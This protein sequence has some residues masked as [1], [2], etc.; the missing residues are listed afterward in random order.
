MG[1]RGQQLVTVRGLVSE[2]WCKAMTPGRH[3]ELSVTSQ[4]SDLSPT[5]SKASH[6][7]KQDC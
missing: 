2:R 1:I 3:A 5:V 4:F 6:Y 7:G